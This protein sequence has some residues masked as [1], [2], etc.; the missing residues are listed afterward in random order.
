MWAGERIYMVDFSRAKTG[1]PHRRF[2]DIDRHGYQDAA[3]TSEHGPIVSAMAT[4]EE[5]TVLF[6]RTE[7]STAAT[8][9]ATSLTFAL[10]RHFAC[11]VSRNPS[12]CN[13]AL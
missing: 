4:Q 3:N 13:A 9:F 10:K 7:I 2:P 12:G 6:H 5:V 8:H 11:S 1:L